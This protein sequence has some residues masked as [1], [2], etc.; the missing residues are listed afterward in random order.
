MAADPAT[1]LLPAG[2]A[3]LSSLVEEREALPRWGRELGRGAACAVYVARDDEGAVVKASSMPL[4][5]VHASLR[6][7][8]KGA[9]EAGVAAAA[10]A[11]PPLLRRGFA[12]TRAELHDCREDARDRV[13]E[14]PRAK[15]RRFEVTEVDWLWSPGEE[16]GE[17]DLLELPGFACE[18]AV[19]GLVAQ[20]VAPACPHFVAARLPAVRTPRW[21]AVVA[22]RAHGTVD[23]LLHTLGRDEMRAIAFQLLVALHAGQRAIGFKHHDA[24]CGNVF[25]LLL[26]PA[27]AARRPTRF[28]HVA[29]PAGFP[30]GGGGTL[31]YVLA[32]R[33]FRV[34]HRGFF[35]KLGDYDKASAAHPARPGLRYAR[36]DFELLGVL[37][38]EERDEW[39]PWDGQLRGRR[40]YDAQYFVSYAL[41][42]EKERLKRETARFLRSMQAR[43]GGPLSA[44]EFGRPAHGLVS[45]VPPLDLLLDKK[46]FGDW[47][48]ADDGAAAVYTDAA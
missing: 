18:V 8:A 33:R 10:A 12:R 37:D 3:W 46:L 47:A 21:G 28:K 45:D 16:E 22:Q 9:R 35:V 24:H 6:R 41:T 26:D 30:H 48:V 40:G 44:T 4:Q 19:A 2:L 27:L 36:C 25:L 34:P 17:P 20:F 14:L 15:R 29:L 1:S 42:Q 11:A 7:E 43:L 32:G 38:E 13:R 39:G 31:D 5:A 23:A